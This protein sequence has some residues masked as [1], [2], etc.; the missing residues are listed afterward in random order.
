MSIDDATILTKVTGRGKVEYQFFN[1][2]L[3]N[4]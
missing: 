2:S 1:L 4:K 3:N